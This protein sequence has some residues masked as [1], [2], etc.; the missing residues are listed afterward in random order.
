MKGTAEYPA[1]RQEINITIRFVDGDVFVQPIPI[2]NADSVQEFLDW[3]RKPG[4]SKIWSWHVPT[5]SIIHMLNHD[6]IMGVDV[7][8]Y[9]E[10]DGRESKWYEKLIDR[11]RVRRLR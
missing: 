8:G 11:I 4:K 10:P 9:L 7:E 2:D 3:F 1:T 6:H 5:H